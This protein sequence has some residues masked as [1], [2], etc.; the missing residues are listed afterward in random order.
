MHR[1][2][3]GTTCNMPDSARSCCYYC[4]KD[5]GLLMDTPWWTRCLCDAQPWGRKGC[6]GEQRARKW[7]CRQDTVESY[8]PRQAHLRG[9]GGG[10]VAYT[11]VARL[12]D[13]NHGSEGVTSAVFFLSWRHWLVFMQ[14][15]ALIASQSVLS[16]RWSGGAP[17]YAWR[18]CN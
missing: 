4:S 13:G 10:N 3:V 11:D 1:G 2:S 17:P 14:A 16:A 7:V 5:N 6:P 9:S 12:S 15:Q 18:A 8:L